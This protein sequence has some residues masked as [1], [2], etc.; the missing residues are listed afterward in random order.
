MIYYATDWPSVHM[1]ECN[2]VGM[3]RGNP[4]SSLKQGSK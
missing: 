4:A 2:K 3:S 1:I